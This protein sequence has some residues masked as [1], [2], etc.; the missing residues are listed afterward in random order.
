MDC[1]P[2]YGRLRRAAL[3]MID[4]RWQLGHRIHS[5]TNIIRLDSG[6]RSISSAARALG[7]PPQAD[8]FDR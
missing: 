4:G 1:L 6:Q 2:V 3:L 8:F 5:W 7:S